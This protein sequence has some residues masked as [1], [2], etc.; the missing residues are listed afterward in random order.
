MGVAA[1]GII[2][3]IALVVVAI[4]NGVAQ[5]IQP[6]ISSAYGKNRMKEAGRV[7]FYS[8]VTM[9]V[10]SAVMYGG[11]VLFADPIAAVFNS[12]GLLKLQEMAVEGL[13]LYFLSNIFVGFNTI[14]AMYFSATE[15]NLPAHLL[16]LLRGLVL[17]VPAA[18][19]M[20][21]VW[22]MTGVWLACT[23]TEAAVAVFGAIVYRRTGRKSAAERLAGA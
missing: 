9:L 15:R 19:F 10:S 11:I 22:G 20:A 6:L 13:K 1:Y 16:S 12:E 21:A 18:F 5:G 23:V 8:M 2:T 17:I 14:L 7:L 3:N 4:Y